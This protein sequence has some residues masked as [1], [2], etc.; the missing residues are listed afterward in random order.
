M[1][2]KRTTI[3]IEDDIWNKLRHIALDKKM[4]TSELLEEL[5]KEKLRNKK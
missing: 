1:V 2:K 4:S 3:Y 5:V